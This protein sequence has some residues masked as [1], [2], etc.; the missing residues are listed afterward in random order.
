MNK[1]HILFK[2]QLILLILISLL[3]NPNSQAPIYSQSKHFY[4]GQG[5][6]INTKTKLTPDFT[7]TVP[8]PF[9]ISTLAHRIPLHGVTGA[10][11]LKH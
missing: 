2:M 5:S 4:V 8:T 3:W 11:H 6:V 10:S 1:D 7:F 9:T